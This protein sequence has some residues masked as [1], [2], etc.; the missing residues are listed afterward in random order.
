M[1]NRNGAKS[2]WAAACIAIGFLQACSNGGG[3]SAPAPAPP[4]P[5]PAPAPAAPTITAQPADRT[6]LQDGMATFT[7]AATNAT[8]Y[9]WQRS[10]DGATW[11]ALD[12]AST[13][14]LS[15]PEPLAGGDLRYRVVVSGA[16]GQVTSDA[17]RLT[18][19]PMLYQ[20]PTSTSVM[21]GQ[22]AQFIA[23]PGFD[24]PEIPVQ[25]QQSRDGQAWTDIA[26][27][28]APSLTLPAVALTDN[29]L[30][31]REVVTAF[32]NTYTSTVATLFVYADMTIASFMVQPLDATVRSG[33]TARFTAW[34]RP[35]S[36]PQSYQWQSSS[37]HGTHWS[38]LPG[39]NMQALQLFGMPTSANGEQVRL[40]VTI[41]GHVNTSQVAT[42][43]VGTDGAGELDL[44]AGA[45]GGQV[46]LDGTGTGA[47]LSG[48]AAPAFDTHGNLYFLDGGKRFKR[49]DPAGQVTSLAGRETGGFSNG[50]GAAAMFAGWYGSATVASPN[51]DFFVLEDDANDVKR[52]A[53]DGTVSIFVGQYVAGAVDGTGTAASF[54]DP[55]GLAID[56]AGNLF[57][58]DTGN[59]TIR[60]ITPAGVV[61]TVAGTA[62]ASGSADGVA[63]VARLNSPSGI[64]V[65]AQGKVSFTDAGNTVRQ[66]SATQGVTTLAGTAGTSGAADGDGAAARF[67]RPLGIAVDGQGMLYVA[68]IDNATIRRVTPGGTVT[69]VAGSPGRTGLDDGVGSSARFLVPAYVAVAPDGT[70][71]V[72]DTSRIRRISLA[73][74]VTTLAGS[75]QTRQHVD[76]AGAVAR[77]QT[78]RSLVTTPA[79]TILLGDGDGS[80]REVARDGTTTSRASG[81][82]ADAMLYDDAGNLI[83]SNGTFNC[84]I[85]Q[86]SPQ[87]VMTVLAG[88]SSTCARI[89][90]DAATARF[91]WPRGIARGP[92]GE[93]YVIDGTALRK[94][95][96]N[97]DVTTLTSTDSKPHCE[98]GP[99]SSVNLCGGDGIVADE[100]GNLFIADSSM[101][102]RVDAVTHQ[103]TAIAGNKDNDQTNLDG[104]GTA[105]RFSMLHAITRDTAGNLYVAD[106]VGSNIRRIDPAGN[107]TTLVGR[108]GLDGIVVGTAPALV[109][110]AALAM[111]DATHLAVT[112][113]D[114]LL[115]Y[116]LPGGTPF[117]AAA[118]R[119]GTAA[120]AMPAARPAK[121]H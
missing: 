78:P 53:A 46:D 70:L 34:A 55:H 40:V 117:T 109:R 50:A 92:Q 85:R 44:L 120:K 38:D 95:S 25:W 52:I 103:V 65:D 73:N 107:V 104:S 110:P 115:V 88:N 28:T 99:L 7:V 94:L 5:A 69:T 14:T 24:H 19:R 74:E 91:Y 17:A 82:Y 45:I 58:A 101:V 26:G 105:A 43:H 4:P 81:G 6:V 18:V 79:G 80:L 108:A 54:N 57:V 35:T 116:T 112:S 37:D 67:K 9:A 33:N 22:R 96:P 86:I 27:A 64:A 62:G 76:G 63:G 61:S 3:D 97:G 60:R 77:F 114:A 100:A 20:Q 121:V 93:L 59:H 113:M 87:G 106:L 23:G 29:G 32:G 48:V 119:R 98:D 12:G 36:Y 2:A 41:N 8:S 13:P 1:M 15:L 47:W 90:G 31:L 10:T 66:W 84:V 56:S 68:D 102:R 42:L 21:E 49:L 89:D 11:T 16:G 72:T 71:A 111:V 51:G 118:A 75:V 30:S 83:V 39:A